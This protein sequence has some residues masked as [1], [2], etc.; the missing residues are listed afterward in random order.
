MKTTFEIDLDPSS[1]AT[2]FPTTRIKD[3]FK[4]IEIIIE[5]ARYMLHAKREK[6]ARGSY[7]MIFFRD[8]M[9]RIFFV[10]SDKVYS[11]IFPFNVII[12]ENN[13]SLNY[14]NLIEI[15]SLALSNLVILLKNP[16]IQSDNCLDFIDPI[17]DLENEQTEKYWILFKDLLITEDGYIRYDKDLVGYNEAKEKKQEHRHP[18]HHLDVFYTNAATFKIGLNNSIMDRELIDT[19]NTE[20]DCKYLNC[21]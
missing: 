8:K 16:L 2:F 5:S 19:V 11:V 12:H 9:S 7:K 17:I 10:S 18:I 20:T 15:D 3:K 4:I 6:K 14:K 1:L 21:P 13:L